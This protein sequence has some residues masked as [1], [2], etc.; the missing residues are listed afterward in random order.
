MN[1]K[2]LKKIGQGRRAFLELDIKKSGVNKFHKYNY[3]ELDDLIPPHLALCEKLK[4]ETHEDFDDDSKAKLHVYDLEQGDDQEPVTFYR[5]TTPVSNGDVTK[6]MQ[7]NGSSQKYAWRYLLCQ[8]WNVSE[9]DSIDAGKLNMKDKEE[10]PPER[11]NELARELGKIVYEGGGNNRDKK[12]LL[13]EL[14]SQLKSKT[15]TNR[16]Y[17]EVKKLI[18]NI[19]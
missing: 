17:D 14:D 6:G 1:I 4:I 16:E 13:S 10:I 3:Y 2:T 12:Q 9:A 7:E 11:V 19:H 18:D 15:I 8:L 5:P